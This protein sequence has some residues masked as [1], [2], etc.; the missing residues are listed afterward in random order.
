MAKKKTADS[1]V[2]F[3]QIGQGNFSEIYKAKEKKSEVYY[4]IK[5]FNKRRVKQLNK[6]MEIEM[7]RY[8]LGKLRGSPYFIDYFDTFESED[9]LYVQLELVNGI[10]LWEKVRLFGLISEPLVRYFLSHLVMAVEY[11][12]GK[13]IV[14]RDL[15]SENILINTEYQIKIVDFGTAKD[16]YD[17]KYK[18]AGTG[19]KER[20]N[21]EHYV[22][23]PNYMPPECIRNQASGFPSDI[24][25][26]GG[27]A[28]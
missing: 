14:H 3:T 12:H 9:E 10:E 8:C 24:Y 2:D 17:P 20:K 28:F 27:C 26:L 23:T 5:K 4:A 6:E 25:A 18:G 7:E 16:A 19:R 15:K 11:M 21:Y 1:F 22:G 13:G